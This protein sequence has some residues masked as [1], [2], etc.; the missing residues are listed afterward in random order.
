M[1]ER[2]KNKKLRIRKLDRVFASRIYELCLQGYTNVEIA[3]T[4]DVHYNT[5]S[6]WRS[7]N[8]YFKSKMDELRSE[9]AKTIVMRAL[10]E[11]ASG[12]KTTK[13]TYATNEDGEEILIKREVSQDA[14]NIKAVQIVARQ[15]APELSDLKE[16]EGKKV[17]ISIDSSRMNLRELQEFNAE[18]N[19]LDAEYQVLDA[20]SLDD[21]VQHSDSE[22]SEKDSDSE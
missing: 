2:D 9:S 1:G 4:L 20:V 14:P 7:N 12:A 16:I 5:L 11:S 22:D 21:L 13:E 15:V 17:E 19:P 10:R 18:N 8:P 3:K 6:K